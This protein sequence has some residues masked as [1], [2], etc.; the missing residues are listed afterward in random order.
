MAAPRRSA[1]HFA[2]L[3]EMVSKY[4]LRVALHRYKAIRI[5]S[6]RPS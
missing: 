2:V 5:A 4:R 1:G 3:A 6:S